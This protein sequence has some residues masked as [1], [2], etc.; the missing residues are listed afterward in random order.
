MVAGVDT[1]YGTD[2]RLLPV[3]RVH[4]DLQKEFATDLRRLSGMAHDFAFVSK[5][6]SARGRA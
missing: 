1:F 4:M 2:G 6:F 3:F 5:L